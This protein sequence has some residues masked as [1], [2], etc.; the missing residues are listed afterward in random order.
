MWEMESDPVGHLVPGELATCS[1][2]LSPA[3]ARPPDYFVPTH[4][5]GAERIEAD[6]PAQSSLGVSSREVA[7]TPSEKENVLANR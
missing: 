1:L 6:L 4:G 3:S 5:V 2:A 7:A